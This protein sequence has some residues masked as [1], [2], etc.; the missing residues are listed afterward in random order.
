[1]LKTGWNGSISEVAQADLNAKS[2]ARRKLRRKTLLWLAAG[3]AASG[4]TATAEAQYYEV[5]CTGATPGDYATINA[6][7]TAAGTRPV[8]VSSSPTY[9]TVVAGPCNETVN[10]VNV[11]NL[12]LGVVYGTAPISLNGSV[13]V[14]GSNS[15]FLYGLTVTNPAGNAFNVTSSHDV[16]LQSCSGNGSAGRGLQVRTLS[17]VSITGPGTFD[18]NATGGINIGGSSAV[19]VSNWN[20]STVEIGHNFG[21]GVWLSEGSLFGA[22]GLTTIDSNEN[23]SGTTPQDGFGIEALGGS[24]VQIG[25]CFGNNAIEDNQAGGIDAEENTELSLWNCGDPYQ[26]L[27]SGN[28]PVGIIGG[29]G[30]QVTLYENAQIS[31]HAGSGIDVYGNS[32][33]RVYGANLISQNGSAGDRRSAG[34][35]VD[36]NSEAYLRGG[37]I[38]ANEGPGILALVNSSAD[39]TGAG[40]SGNAGGVITCDSSSTMVSDLSGKG[41]DCRM[42]HNLGNRRGRSSHP[43][44][45]DLTAQKLKF[46]KFKAAASRKP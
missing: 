35:V 26:T 16:T 10:L 23:E 34:I 14:T 2:A 22:I 3:L 45:P 36:G 15:V 28:G 11:S 25:T 4:L 27:V 32:Q 37:T 44:M 19:N 40:L 1:M 9:V 38:T 7:L 21:P 46:A 29:L 31:G 33:L 20:G 8:T 41:V 5:D 39:F 24:R 43:T 18:G 42:P 30:A 12:N 13:N 17:D 6:A